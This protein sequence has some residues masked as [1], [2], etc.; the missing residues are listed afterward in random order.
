MG[1]T[2]RLLRCVRVFLSQCVLVRVCTCDLGSGVWGVG[3]G[4]EGGRV[5]GQKNDRYRNGNFNKG[6]HQGREGREGRRENLDVVDCLHS[7]WLEGGEDQTVVWQPV[8][9]TPFFPPSPLPSFP[10]T[11][12]PQFPSLSPPF[13]L[14][15]PPP[16]HFPPLSAPLLPCLPRSLASR[17]TTRVAPLAAPPTPSTRLHSS[18][19]S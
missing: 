7:W 4:G 9:C 8:T 12:S 1:P 16:P 6:V 2:A 18:S 13:A 14:P 3:R 17:V 19:G 10:P 15:P 11:L 5:E